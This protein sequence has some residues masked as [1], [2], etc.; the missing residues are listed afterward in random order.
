[1][2]TR[3]MIQA[4]QTSASDKGSYLSSLIGEL[5]VYDVKNGEI[6]YLV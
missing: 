2:I 1:M 6:R 3:N 4:A 5:V